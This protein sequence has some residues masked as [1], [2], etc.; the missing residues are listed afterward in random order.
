V[1]PYAPVAKSGLLADIEFE[2][3]IGH[4]EL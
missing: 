3:V 1:T 4:L 2:V